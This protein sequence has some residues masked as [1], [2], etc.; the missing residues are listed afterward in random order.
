MKKLIKLF[1]VHLL[2]FMLWSCGSDDISLPEENYCEEPQGA[3]ELVQDFYNRVHPESRSLYSPLVIKEINKVP[4]GLHSRG[5]EYELTTVTFSDGVN[6]GFAI[7]SDDN[8]KI[9]YFTSNGSLDDI[10]EIEALSKAFPSLD[11]TKMPGIG[12]PDTTS[13]YWNDDLGQIDEW[14]LAFLSVA[15]IIK[16]QYHHGFPY[17]I[18]N[19]RN[20]SDYACECPECQKNRGYKRNHIMVTA[21]MNFANNGGVG[22]GGG[23]ISP[24]DNSTI[25]PEDGAG[26]T[27]KELSDTWDCM[28]I[29]CLLGTPPYCASLPSPANKIALD[30]IGDSTRYGYRE[31]DGYKKYIGTMKINAA[32]DYMGY[33][34]KIY[35]SLKIGIPVLVANDSSA[36]NID[37]FERYVSGDMFHIVTCFQEGENDGWM[38]ADKLNEVI[39][40][41]TLVLY[42]GHKEK[43]YT[44]ID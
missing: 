33:G 5:D 19:Y 22:I 40:N 1:Q 44:G 12:I 39:G 18:F 24:W 2:A 7:L 11:G 27:Q 10:P 38:S 42:T 41:C 8:Q 29:N 28:R 34:K 15:P 23:W 6:D 26:L 20:Y 37:G 9:L 36:W 35:Y 25:I 14:D 30:I 13:Y 43:I 31:M 17:T 21:L 16:K 3:I 32:T 4:I